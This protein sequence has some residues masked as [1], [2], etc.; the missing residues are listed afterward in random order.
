MLE[1]PNIE[2]GFGVPLGM[3]VNQKLALRLSS[4]VIPA[5]QYPFGL[6]TGTKEEVSQLLSKG[7]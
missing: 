1:M 2:S 4:K 3:I 6:L 7:H 5:A